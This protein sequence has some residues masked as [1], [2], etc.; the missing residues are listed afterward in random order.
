MQVWSFQAILIS[1]LQCTTGGGHVFLYLG[2]V[3]LLIRQYIKIEAVF[4]KEAC[5]KVTIH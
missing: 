5:K 2:N 3:S 4:L 1:F